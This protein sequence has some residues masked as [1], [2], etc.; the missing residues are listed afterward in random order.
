[1]LEA[2][3]KKERKDLGNSRIRSLFSGQSFRTIILSALLLFLV[4]AALTVMKSARDALV[5]TQFPGES[6]PYFMVVTT[7]VIGVVVALQLKLNEKLSVCRVLAGALLF[8][9]IGT[10]AL[11]FGTRAGWWAAVRFFTF[12]LGFSAR[13]FP[14]S[15]GP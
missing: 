3:V 8:F 7:L 6:L 9:A 10:F 11:R 15:G 12:G 1:M 13:R 2:G 4:I 5:L 14:C